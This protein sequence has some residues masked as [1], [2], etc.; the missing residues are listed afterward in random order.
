MQRKFEKEGYQTISTVA[1]PGV[2]VTNLVQHIPFWVKIVFSPLIPFVTHSPENGAKPTLYAALGNDAKGGD[3]F[4][5]TGFN[6]MKG[7]AGKV[8]STPLSHDKEISK[9][10]W[11]VSEELTQ[12]KYL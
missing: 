5:P 4:G 6:Q 10:L 8:D 11:E 1:H 12:T 9:R 3:Y 7:K 2:S